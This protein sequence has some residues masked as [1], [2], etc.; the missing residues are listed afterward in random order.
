MADYYDPTG[1]RYDLL[2]VIGIFLWCPH[3]N[4]ETERPDARSRPGGPSIAWR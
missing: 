3:C 4:N 1:I 2:H